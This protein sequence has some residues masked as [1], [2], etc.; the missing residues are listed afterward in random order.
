MAVAM[1]MTMMVLAVAVVL[2]AVVGL[3]GQEA[4]A[5]NNASI[6]FVRY[7]KVGGT[8]MSGLMLGMKRTYNKQIV[9]PTT[10]IAREPF[11]SVYHYSACNIFMRVN[12]FGPKH[13]WL[14]ISLVREPQAAVLSAFYHFCLTRSNCRGVESQ[15]PKDVDRSSDEFK[16]AYLA[17]HRTSAAEY[18]APCGLRVNASDGSASQAHAIVATYHLVA[19]NERYLESLLVFRHLFDLTFHDILHFPAKKFKQ[20]EKDDYGLPAPAR[21][22]TESE[23]VV[24][25]LEKLANTTLA[26]DTALHRAAVARLD[27]HIDTLGQKKIADEKAFFEKALACAREQCAD[28]Q[29]SDCMEVDQMCG[30]TCLHSVNFER[31]CNLTVPSPA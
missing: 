21:P 14:R 9:I 8:T 4:H 26:A 17:A 23:A 10:S 19:V 2:L 16:L 6:A 29:H 24:G 5:F 25:F 12:R 13:P 1:T 28:Q 15:F 11:Y 3:G 30:Y 27:E 7:F 31:D 22:E 20:G 18:L